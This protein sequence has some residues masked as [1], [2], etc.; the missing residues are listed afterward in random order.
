MHDKH[1]SFS[2]S[3]S[4]FTLIFLYSRTNHIH[5]QSDLAVD[6]SILLIPKFGSRLPFLSCLILFHSIIQFLT[7]RFR[8][9]ITS[10]TPKN[11]NSLRFSIIFQ[12]GLGQ[13]IYCSILY[14]LFLSPLISLTVPS[15]NKFY[16]LCGCFAKI[17]LKV[18]VDSRR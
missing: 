9:K 16:A 15:L 8:S 17:I 1:H 14:I 13:K 11:S 5:F 10:L 7:I 4:K 2:K 12:A 6:F 3:N 18:Q